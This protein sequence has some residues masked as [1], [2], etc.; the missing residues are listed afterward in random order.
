MKAVFALL[1]A[2]VMCA[3]GSFKQMD[4]TYV[5]DENSQQ[6]TTIV[7][8]RK[9]L[10]SPVDR[11][12]KQMPPTATILVHCWVTCCCEWGFGRCTYCCDDPTDCFFAIN[13]TS[14]TVKK[15][16]EQGT[17]PSAAKPR[18]QIRTK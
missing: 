4:A 5:H 12:G 18:E 13:G 16:D 8:A 7:A 15:S 10:L 2:L 3:F 11:T 1:L 6:M 9:L 14:T 17:A